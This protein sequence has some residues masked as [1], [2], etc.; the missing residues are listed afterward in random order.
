MRISNAQFI[1][2]LDSDDIWT[3][4]KLKTQINF[5]LINNCEFTYTDYN[6]FFHKNKNKI[7]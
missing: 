6:K 5:M 4:D 1:S 7:Y 3:S 2:F